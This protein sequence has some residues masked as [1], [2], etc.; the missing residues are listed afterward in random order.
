MKR[1]K[2]LLLQLLDEPEICEKIRSIISVTVD[3]KPTA[4]SV[5]SEAISAEKFTELQ[6]E[7]ERYKTALKN[8]NHLL[9]EK[10]NELTLMRTQWQQLQ[11]E[12]HVA[13]TDTAMST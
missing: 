3:S 8:Q 6:A 9:D 4:L 12:K 1:E 2:E 13:G 11:D 10:Q 5:D 7:L